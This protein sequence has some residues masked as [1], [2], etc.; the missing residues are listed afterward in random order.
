MCSGWDGGECAQ[1]GE[2]GLRLLCNLVSSYTQGNIDL[3][4]GDE[5]E[6]VESHRVQCNTL[7]YEMRRI[8]EDREMELWR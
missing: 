8:H 6:D 2:G 3:V 7:A 1:E 4:S 5:C